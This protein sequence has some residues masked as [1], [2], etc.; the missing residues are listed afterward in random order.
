MKARPTAHQSGDCRPPADQ[1]NLGG[2]RLARRDSAARYD[3][4]QHR[5]RRSDQ[6][7]VRRS[8]GGFVAVSD[9]E[10]LEAMR[11]LTMMVWVLTARP[12]AAAYA[13]LLR[14]LE[15]GLLNR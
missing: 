13:T 11:V 4:R 5:R 6:R 15:S 1:A 12:G 8:G 2:E 7:D 14:V 10:L 9:A 3:R